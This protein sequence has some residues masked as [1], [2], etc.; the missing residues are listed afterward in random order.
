MT[1]SIWPEVTNL[2]T[3]HVRKA[4]KRAATRARLGVG[5]SGRR[6][7]LRLRN[8]PLWSEVEHADTMSATL[9]RR[10]TWV[11]KSARHVSIT[12]LPM[13]LHRQA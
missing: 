4:T 13:L 9:A 12:G 1:G 3:G 6:A 11:P 2:W 8:R 10:P 5:N 7:S